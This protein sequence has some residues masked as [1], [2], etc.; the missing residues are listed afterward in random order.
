MFGAAG[1]VDDENHL[2]RVPA[3]GRDALDCS[4]QLSGPVALREDDAGEPH[5][6]A[7]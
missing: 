7:R 2:H 3:L 1:A 4:L 5:E 6:V